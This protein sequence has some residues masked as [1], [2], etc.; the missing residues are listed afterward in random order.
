MKNIRFVCGITIYNPDCGVLE[1]V[2]E[3]CGSFEKIILFDN[4]ESDN[5]EFYN[6]LKP[7]ILTNK[8]EYLSEHINKGLPYAFNKILNLLEGHKYDYLC[9]LDQDSKFHQEDIKAIQSYITKNKPDDFAVIA[10]HV[11]YHD[12]HF[13]KS[14]AL[15]AKRYVITSGS[16]INLR[17]L[18]RTGIKY[19]ENYFIDR[20]DIDID[21]QLIRA[22][23]KVGE[24]K[25]AVLYQRLGTFSG[26]K[27][28]NHSP[29]RH[30]Y[31]F[32]NRFYYNFK[33]FS[34][35]KGLVLSILQT[36]KHICLILLFEEKKLAK[37]LQ[38]PPAISDYIKGKMGIRKEELKP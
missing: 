20:F 24:Y 10:P 28:P 25:G 12:E 31:L 32:R 33:F 9:T 18:G 11:I 6:Y 3:Y 14:D 1:R 29:Q 35:T 27:H 16:F 15:T 26:H 30:Y 13:V 36:V 17:I 19:D 5:I 7:Y 34:K 21:Q 22:G 8:I 4:T 2:V 38:L 37:I 23:F